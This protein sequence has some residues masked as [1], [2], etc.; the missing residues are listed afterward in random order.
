M[1]SKLLLALAAT[2]AALPATA[3]AHHSFAAFFDPNKSVTV[4]GTVTAFRFTNPHGMVVLN[5]K[6]PDGTDEEWR[7]ET[8]APVVLVHRGW[9]R[10]SIKPGQVV[11][12]DGW[13]AR[14][15]RNYIRLRD[16]KDAEGK[17]I[18][19]AAFGQKDQS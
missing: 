7:A 3:Q 16:A 15:G 17:P 9:T 18:G 5:V 13:P 14:D 2:L 10:D 12:I 6:K 1:P 11:T 19:A 4:T 8:N